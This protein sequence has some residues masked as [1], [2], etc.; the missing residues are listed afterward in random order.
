MSTLIVSIPENFYLQEFNYIIKVLLIDFLGLDYTLEMYDGDK[1]KI[2]LKGDESDKALIIENILFNTPTEEWLKESSLPLSPLPRWNILDDLPE[3]RLCK[4]DL[5]IIYGRLLSNGRYFDQGKNFIHLGVDIFG[6]CFFMLTRYE[7]IIV[8]ERDE[9]ERFPAKASLAYRE[10]FLSRPIV[11]EYVEILWA[12]LKRLWPGLERKQH[13]YKVLLTHD[14][15]HP[16]V[17]YDQSW[18]Q[19]LRNVSADLI[20]RKNISLSF[21]R[22]KCKVKNDPKLDPANTFDFIMDLSEKNGL[23]SEF[24]FITDH[25]AGTL[26]GSDYSLESPY[27]QVLIDRIYKRGHRIG[28]HASY[29]S[30]C[31][32]QQIKREFEKLIMLAEKLSIKQDSYGGRQHYLRWK[33]PTTWQNWEDTG[34]NYDSTLSFADYAGFRTGVCYEYP[35]YNL[36]TR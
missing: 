3:V 7:E 28:L 33:N 32:S 30:Y 27:I 18:Y 10:G 29:N 8:S 12:L 26:D 6:S 36:V 5:P 24:Y 15:D 20:N 9:H 13:S 2:R 17:V 4:K 21:Q 35:V 25:P 16:F 1:V 14:V 11:N 34:L 23:Q 22:I 31:D 19:I